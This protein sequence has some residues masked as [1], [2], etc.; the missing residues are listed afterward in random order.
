M[1]KRNKI[2]NT[3]IMFIAIGVFL[4]HGAGYALRPP[5]QCSSTQ[6]EFIEQL[7]PD[8]RTESD[9]QVPSQSVYKKHILRIRDL[10]SMV[11]RKETTRKNIKAEIITALLSIQ[12]DGSSLFKQR[13][14]EKIARLRKLGG[15]LSILEHLILYQI[16]QS[17][18]K[19]FLFN[20]THIALILHSSRSEIEIKRVIGTLKELG[21]TEGTHIALIL[22]SSRSEIEIKRVIGTLKELGITEGY[23]IA[24]I[25]QSSRSEI[26]IKHLID[27]KKIIVQEKGDS[28]P[29]YFIKDML[30]RFVF[31][32]DPLSLLREIMN[33]DFAKVRLEIEQMS[34][35]T[36][37]EQFEQRYGNM[38]IW[39][40]KFFGRDFRSLKAII[41]GYA[42]E[43][44]LLDIIPE[45]EK[46]IAGHGSVEVEV[47]KVFLRESMEKVIS[48]LSDR[49]QKVVQMFL[50]GYSEQEISS[51][52]SDV[53]M[54][55][56][57]GKLRAIII[58]ERSLLDTIAPFYDPTAEIIEEKGP[59][60][61]GFLNKEGPAG[62]L[63][64]VM[65][66]PLKRS[67]LSNS[68]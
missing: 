51:K 45:A 57:F 11:D 63:L 17:G 46:V 5:L 28:Y 27:L 43:L 49:E 52:Y 47:D 19:K 50:E 23:H 21:I 62:Q 41:R 40:L 64:N 16:E 44:L 22:H 55:E 61:T 30:V 42:K 2:I 66:Q 9:K 56:V 65:G 13:Q 38:G 25:L 4:R 15:R 10:L 36:T 24:L 68:I 53:S 26:E 14:A 32:D 6:R 67:P 48:R 29:E 59:K 3:V 31:M 1:R 18:K 12:R 60:E 33:T 39:I 58:G 37:R 35:G 20:G 7:N 8:T 34:I 54:P